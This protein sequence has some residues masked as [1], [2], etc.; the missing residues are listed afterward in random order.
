MLQK[1]INDNNESK[2]DDKLSDSNKQL[3]GIIKNLLVFNP[4][5]RI[6]AEECLKSK[7]FDDVRDP[8]NESLESP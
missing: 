2:L 5:E 1:N 7:Y 8:R 3:V 4:D 6:S